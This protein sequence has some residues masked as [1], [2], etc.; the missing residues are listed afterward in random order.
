[1]TEKEYLDILD[2]YYSIKSEREDLSLSEEDAKLKEELKCA[3]I[4]HNNKL[5]EEFP[6]L[7]CRNVFTDEKPESNLFTWLD[8]MPEGWRI[9]FGI[10]LCK[11]LKEALLKANALDDY[12]IHQVKEKFG[13]LRWYDSFCTAETRVIIDR[14]EVLSEKTCIK[15]GKPAEYSTKN[16]ISPYCK[17]C[18]DSILENAQRYYTNGVTF[19][20]YFHKLNFN[21]DILE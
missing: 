6:F 9:A 7:E 14:Y 8:D 18:A 17:E 20:N 13:G 16:W 4:E 21:Q 12:R 2:K 5:V 19:D 3:I 1:M 11:E 15:C 10:D